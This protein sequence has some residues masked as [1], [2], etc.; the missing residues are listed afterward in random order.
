MLGGYLVIFIGIGVWMGGN[1]RGIKKN[2]ERKSSDQKRGSKKRFRKRSKGI[3]NI[4]YIRLIY[5]YIYII[6]RPYFNPAFLPT[7]LYPLP[8]FDT[9]IPLKITK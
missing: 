9:P 2:G 8:F 7:L 1:Q 6:V 3:V 5:Y 4:I